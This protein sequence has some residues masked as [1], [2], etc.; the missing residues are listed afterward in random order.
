MLICNFRQRYKNQQ[1]ICFFRQFLPIPQ[2][3]IHT[4]LSSNNARNLKRYLRSKVWRDR[5]RDIVN[6]LPTSRFSRHSSSTIIKYLQDYKKG[7]FQSA[8]DIIIPNSK[9]G[10]VINSIQALPQSAV[11]SFIILNPLL[12]LPFHDISATMDISVKSG[13]IFISNSPQV[14]C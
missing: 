7:K 1:L 12:T 5:Q 8:N 2:I 14:R 3:P 9:E 6:D 4:S 10:G 13:V 11:P